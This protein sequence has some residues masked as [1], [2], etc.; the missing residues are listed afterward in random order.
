MLP[1]AQRIAFKQIIAKNSHGA[2]LKCLTRD[3]CNHSENVALQRCQRVGL[4]IQDTQRAYAHAVV[5]YDGRARIEANAGLA[6]HKRVVSEPYILFGIGDFKNLPVRDNLFTERCLSRCLRETWQSHV[7]FEPLP[8][9]PQQGD[10]GDWG[11]GDLC[12]S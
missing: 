8:V 2:L 1:F 4:P 12:S 10:Q 5:Q 6:D 7:S 11:T 3:P 9:F